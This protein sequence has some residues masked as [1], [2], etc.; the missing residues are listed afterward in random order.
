MVRHFS[1]TFIFLSAVSAQFVLCSL[2]LAKS[3]AYTFPFFDRR[4]R[5]N[6][7]VANIISQCLYSGERRCLRQSLC[8]DFCADYHAVFL[9]LPVSSVFLFAVLS[10]TMQT[11]DC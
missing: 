11:L 7:I 8:I 4:G 10:C 1:L 9:L 2:V 3:V 5:N 6:K